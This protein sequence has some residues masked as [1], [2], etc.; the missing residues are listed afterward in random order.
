[1]SPMKKIVLLL[2][3]I[4]SISGTGFSQIT[5]LADTAFTTDVGFGGAPASCKYQPNGYWFGN[6]IDHNTGW[7]I[8]DFFAVPS[9]ATWLF[10][11][12]IVF[13]YQI[14]SSTTSP[15]SNGYLRIY[16]DG[17]PG[18]GG[19]VIWGDSVTD[20]LVSTGFT[21]IYRVDTAAANGGLTSTQRP[22]MFLKLHLSPA[23]QLGEGTYWL[24]WSATA[25][26]TGFLDSPPKVLPGRINP[27][28]QAARYDSS[29]TW[30]AI[31]DRS[32]TLGMNKIIKARAGLA[33]VPSINT[34]PTNTLSQNIPNPANNI[35]N[36]SF[37]LHDPS[38]AKLCVYNLMG[39]LVKTLAD[40][41]MAAG[42]HE[43][44][45]EVS[46]LPGG[47]YYYTLKTESGTEGGKM[48]VMH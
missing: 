18:L 37:Y 47:I 21:G 24:A 44:S 36:I 12:V 34:D 8:A 26:G 5:Y 23:P 9:G 31:T 30:G 13:G 40:G 35:T 22:I 42:N 46:D 29:G 32:N 19:T 10:D 41:N 39:Q 7:W 14:G 27:A 43:V 1:M 17:P 4:V 11:T 28:G 25:S 48:Q 33:A 45:F 15:F 16:Q 6:D 20:V 3:F 2:A 38:Y